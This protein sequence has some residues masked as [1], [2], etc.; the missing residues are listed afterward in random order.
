MHK[1]VI[2]IFCRPVAALISILALLAGPDCYCATE[3]ITSGTPEK[4]DSLAFASADWHWQE[5]GRGAQPGYAQFEIFG[6]TQSIAVVRYKGRK[7]HTGFVSATGDEAGPTDTLA[8][9]AGAR[10]ALNGSYFNMKTLEP[11][12]FFAIDG[13][14]LGSTYEDELFRTNGLLAVRRKNGRKLDVLPF[15]PARES[16][17]NRKFYASLASGPVL[18]TDGKAEEFDTSDR[19]VTDRHPRSL[20]GITPD[21][22]VY[23]VVV[24]GRF[25]GEAAGASIPELA[26][27]AGW[28]GLKDA[29]NFDGGGSSA[30]WTDDTGIINH[31]CDNRKFDHNGA[32]RVPNIIVVTDRRQSL[33]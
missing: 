23:L 16:E 11:A 3:N 14:Q 13:E 21:G 30:V 15:D 5:L 33:R 1:H 10:F 19:F 4:E 29:I 32:R 25:K 17:Y 12:T 28:L 18:M 24:D 6:S 27:I 9:R 31:P 22:T 8:V 20:V 7:Y 2:R 26:R